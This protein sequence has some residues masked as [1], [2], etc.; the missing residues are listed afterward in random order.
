MR[1]IVNQRNFLFSEVYK[2]IHQFYLEKLNKQKD[3]PTLVLDGNLDLILKID[4]LNQLI[5]KENINL[6]EYQILSLDV[7][8]LYGNIDLETS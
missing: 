3:K 6:D 4:K 8:N 2:E 5:E 7:T 1:P